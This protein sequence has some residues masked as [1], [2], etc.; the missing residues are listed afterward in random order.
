MA[1]L[2]RPL[3]ELLHALEVALRLGQRDV[4]QQVLDAVARI[5]PDLAALHFFRG[6]Q[7]L[8]EAAGPRAVAAF[9]IAAGRDPLDPLIW[10]GLAEA[11]TDQGE[12]ESA[13]ER[14]QLLNPD[15]SHAQL[16]HDLRTSKPHLAITPLHRLTARFPERGEIAILLAEAH[17]RMGNETEARVLLD[18][19]LRRRPRPAPALFL[20][21]ALSRDAAAAQQHLADAL[22]FDPLG[23]SAQQ[24][25]APNPLPFM[26]PDTPLVPISAALALLLDALPIDRPMAQRPPNVRPAARISA[27]KSVDAPSKPP[28]PHDSETVAALS[29][30]EQAAQRLLNRAPLAPEARPSTAVFV[31]H[32]GA[33][34][35]AYG[36]D[37]AAAIFRAAEQYGTALGSRGVQA[38][39]VVVD[40]REALGRFGNITPAVERSP[41]ACKQTIDA[42][43]QTIQSGGQ[44][45]DAVV[46]IGG[47]TFIPFHRLPNPSQDADTDVPTDNPYGCGAGSELAPELIVARFPDGGADNGTLLLDQLERAADYHQNWHLT[48]PKGGI[49]SI[50][51]MRRLA[52]P[53]QAGG[54]VGAWG[55]SAA[56]WQLPSQAVYDELGSTRPL[57]LCPP[58]TPVD[59]ERAWPHDARL[60]YFNLHGLS[61]G[62]NWY[63][64]PSDGDVGAPLPVAFGATDIKSISPATICMTEACF[65]AEIVG[66]TANDAIAL[67]MLQSG[68]LAVVGSTATAYGAVTLPLGGAD[69][70][71]QQTM[72]NLRRGH[73]LGQAVALARDW[74]AREM[75]QRQGY[76]DPDDA[77]TLLSFVLLGDPWATPY[78]KP[79]LERK[80]ALP[81]IRPIVVQRQPLAANLVAPAAVQVAKQMIAKAAPSLARASL[82]AVGQGRPD[83][84]AKGQASA[85]VFSASEALPT[86]DGQRLERI[87]RVTV[88]GGAARKF[89]LSR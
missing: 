76:L 83:K 49:L 38:A 8:A 20:A 73:P 85:V 19:L 51:F 45:V 59:I 60:L 58:A 13:M 61:G 56:A 10:H 9:R 23:R 37:V 48:G 71:I 12:R 63:G 52:K 14:A 7:A 3:D 31:L 43:V 4:V 50:P 11:T 26:L 67:R 1:H 88:A 39:T 55:V 65:G 68:A 32:R 70:L 21:A 86:I 22:R 66:R 41:G 57:L 28:A 87:A 30:V 18:P 74:M 25:F 84:I 36:T 5:S 77:K 54:P 81:Q 53:F 17:R 79:V 6:W 80:T 62:P 16:W 89:L 72:Q 33:L 24:L 75:V 42:V 78:T 69:L 2:V 44:D 64:Q 29:A 27:A 46:L 34:E 47:D 82:T 15:G 35:Q 40:D